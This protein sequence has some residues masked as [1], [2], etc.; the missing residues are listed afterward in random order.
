MRE[1]LVAAEIKSRHRTPVQLTGV[2]RAGDHEL[3]CGEFELAG[4][5]LLGQG[6]ASQTYQSAHWNSFLV[7]WS[8]HLFRATHAE[9]TSVLV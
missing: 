6:D 8:H 3:V 2:Q 1:V 7:S 4:D 5:L 9:E